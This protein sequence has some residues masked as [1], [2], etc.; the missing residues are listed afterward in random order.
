V[1]SISDGEQLVGVSSDGQSVVV[2]LEVDT[3][4]VIEL[5]SL[6]LCEN[7]DISLDEDTKDAELNKFVSE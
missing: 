2:A 7:L 4:V 1:D 6:L 3:S 5:D